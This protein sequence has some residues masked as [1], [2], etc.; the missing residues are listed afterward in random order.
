RGGDRPRRRLAHVQDTALD[1]SRL[2]RLQGRER[3]DR[4]RD[5]AAA[6]PLR[7]RPDEDRRPDD[8]RG[9]PVGDSPGADATDAAVE[10]RVLGARPDLRGARARVGG[11]PAPGLPGRRRLRALDRGDGPARPAARRAAEGRAGRHCVTQK[12]PVPA[13]RWAFWWML[14][15]PAL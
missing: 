3:P 6:Q 9:A 10:E 7:D 4:P 12:P 5:R 2:P 13:W 1:V 11:A 14:L 15:A 8:R